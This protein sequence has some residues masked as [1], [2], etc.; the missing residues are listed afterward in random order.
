MKLKRVVLKGSIASLNYKASFE[1]PTYDLE[2]VDNC[3]VV[4]KTVWIPLANV[5]EMVAMPEGIGMIKEDVTTE[6][7]LKPKKSQK[8]D[9]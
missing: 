4:D 8:K 1:S 5:M 3:V 6:N 9:L 2:L 7:L